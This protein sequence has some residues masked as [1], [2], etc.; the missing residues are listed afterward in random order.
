MRDLAPE[1][2]ASLQ[3][4]VVAVFLCKTVGTAYVG[5][6]PSPATTSRNGT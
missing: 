4:K 3:V 5:S 6:N 1:N 2:G